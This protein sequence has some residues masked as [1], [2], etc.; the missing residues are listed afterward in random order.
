MDIGI[1]FMLTELRNWV[2]PTAAQ[3]N[4]LL[5]PIS[6]GSDSALTF[7][8]LNAVYPD[9]TLGVF[10]GNDLRAREWFESEGKIRFLPALASRQHAEVERNAIFQKLAL[11]ENR[12][13]VGTRNRTENVFG[14]FS[15]ASRVATYLPIVGVWKSDVMR[16]CSLIGVPEEVT[17]SSRRA[18]P[19]CGRP[20]ELAEISLELIDVFLKVRIGHLGED[21]LCALTPAQ[22]EYLDKAYKANQFRT[23]LPTEGP[24]LD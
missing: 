19:D 14:T 23:G 24:Q 6:G 3:A 15:L 18:D 1:S 8:I 13:L 9:K 21:A 16:L 5:V 11:D 22:V 2:K 7:H 12:W 4:G 10:V 20:A 17:V